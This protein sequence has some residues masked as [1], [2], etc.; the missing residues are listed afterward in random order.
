MANLEDLS[1]ETLLEL[2]IKALNDNNSNL[3]GRVCELTGTIPEDE[4]STDGYLY[5]VYLAEK[6]YSKKYAH[7]EKKYKIPGRTE[8]PC[9]EKGYDR[10]I[11]DFV[12]MNEDKEIRLPKDYN[13]KSKKQKA[14]MFYGILKHYEI[15]E[16]DIVSKIVKF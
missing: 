3:F 6:E 13:K 15:S 11:R 5:L 14:G 7:K 12:K 10:W 16:E 2:R 1:Y 9:T 4:N 8:I